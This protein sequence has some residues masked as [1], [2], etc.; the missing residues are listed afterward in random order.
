MRMRDGTRRL[1]R[2]TPVANALASLTL[3]T[4]ETAR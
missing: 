3:L 2:V 4:R 1:N